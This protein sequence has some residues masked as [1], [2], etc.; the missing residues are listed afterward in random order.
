MGPLAVG[1]GILFVLIG[2]AGYGFSESHSWTALIPAGLGVLLVLCGLLARQDRLRMHVMHLAALLGLVGF[3]G[4]VVMVIL[5][6]SKGVPLPL[7]T[8]MKGLL[9]VT[10]GIF[11]ALC[12]K[13]FVD[14]RRLRA[15]NLTTK[16][17]RAQRED[18]EESK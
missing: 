4:G 15:G 12:I 3:V 13:S 5:D 1:F 10:A 17:Q 16:T 2:L 7:A 14:A 18:Q 8:A 9:A 6:L 11:L